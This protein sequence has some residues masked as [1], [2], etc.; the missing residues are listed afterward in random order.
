MGEGQA[1]RFIR[2]DGEGQGVEALPGD[3]AVTGNPVGHMNVVALTT[4]SPSPMIHMRFAPRLRWRIQRHHAVRE[5]EVPITGAEAPYRVIAPADPDAVLDQTAR[6]FARHEAAKAAEGAQRSQALA[7]HGSTGLVGASSSGGWHMPYWATPWASGLAV[8]E[9]VVA[10]PGRVAGARV[11]ELGCGL[12][13]TAMALV[14]A[15]ARLTVVDCWGETLA[16]CR[17]NALRAGAQ[18]PPHGAGNR[19]GTIRTRLADWRTDP[20]RDALIAGGPY[21]LV[22]A[23]DVLY[24]P[25]DIPVLFAL[26]PRLVGPVGAVWLAEPGRTTSRKFVQ[27]TDDAG[28]IRDTATVTRDP[29]PADAGRATV[30]LHRYTGIGSA[31]ADLRAPSPLSHHHP[32][33]PDL[34]VRSSQSPPDLHASLPRP[35]TA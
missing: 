6:A 34:Y 9:A 32:T 21:D 7:Q 10:E 2:G 12:G 28:W 15:G 13:I 8:A 3:R 19:A 1:N 26:L 16:F 29:W 17:Y 18:N 24:E 35:H 25:E 31:S 33:P 20:G 14:R 27:E 4:A 22:V 23:A 30:R 5:L 11:M